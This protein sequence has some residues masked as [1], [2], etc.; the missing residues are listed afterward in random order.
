MAE[1]GMKFT[2]RQ[3]LEYAVDYLLDSD[4]PHE[5]VEK[6][7]AMIKQ[8]TKRAEYSATHRK[9]AKAKGPNPE[10]AERAA[11]IESILTGTPVTAAEINQI[12]GTTYTALQ[13]SNACKFIAGVQSQKVTREMV[14]KNGLRAE[15]EYTGY[16]I[17]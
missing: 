14:G 3:A 4:C 16:F 5:V 10:T 13:V 7:E 17:K 2:K 15:R 1:T 11:L 9:P 8:E 6:L 12:L